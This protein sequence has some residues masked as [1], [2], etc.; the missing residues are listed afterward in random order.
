MASPSL[1]TDQEYI[2]HFVVEQAGLADF[3]GPQFSPALQID[4]NYHTFNH[5]TIQDNYW[6]G[7]VCVCY[8]SLNRSVIIG[9]TPAPRIFIDR[10][11]ILQCTVLTFLLQN[12]SFAKLKVH[13]PEFETFCGVS[14]PD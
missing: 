7:T 14:V 4:W 12:P 5:L 9:C 11:N 10:L 2:H 8:G 6:T 3:N 1:V 13:T